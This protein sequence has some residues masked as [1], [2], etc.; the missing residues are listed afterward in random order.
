[1]PNPVLKN[2]WVRAA[3]VLMALAAVGMAAY[4]LSPVLIP[5]F[6]AFFV[7][8]ILDPLVD[9][10]EK[11]GHSRGKVIAVL[12]V[13]GI[14]LLFTI[15]PITVISIKNQAQIL[16]TSSTSDDTEFSD[17]ILNKLEDWIGL[18]EL[19]GLMGWDDSDAPPAPTAEPITEPVEEETAKPEP[20]TPTEEQPVTAEADAPESDAAPESTPETEVPEV[21]VPTEPD[22]DSRAIIAAHVGEYVQDNA[23]TFIRQNSGFFASAGQEAG[24]TVLGVF[25]R[26]GNAIVGLILTL[27]NVAL[28]AFVAGYLLKDF[29]SVTAA[30][31]EL[32]P[33]KYREKTI[34]ITKQIDAQLRAFFRGQL[35]VAMFLGAMYAIGFWLAGTPLA[36]MIGAFGLVASFVPY[37]GV[38]LTSVLAISLTLLA[39]GIDYQLIGV[40]I[41]IGL[42]QFLEGNVLTP[43]IVGEQVGLNPVWVILAVLV[44]G[45][46]LGFLGLLIAVPTAAALKVLVVEAVAYYKRSPV[47]GDSGASG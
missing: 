37:L 5:L 25:Q 11:R 24:V 45:N 44:F 17:K 26:I 10:F 1:M 29:D 39:H 3:L 2:P 28:F 43:K 27:A 15:P 38:V 19:V 13:I 41:T 22:I 8:Y 47:Y 35:T 32:I 36:L 6:T 20:A 21:V 9:R 31:G 18:D 40:F 46:M 16:T 23:A 14:V 12:A 4:M 30:A 34:D 42:A 7:A 33:P